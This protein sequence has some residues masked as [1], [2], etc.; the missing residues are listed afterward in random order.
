MNTF[1]NII[2][3]RNINQYTYFQHGI[4]GLFNSIKEQEEYMDNKTIFNDVM[5]QLKKKMRAVRYGV[6]VSSDLLINRN[7]SSVL[8]YE[9][10]INIY[11]Y[12]IS[13]Y[14][15]YTKKLKKYNKNEINSF[16]IK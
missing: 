6:T 13:A 16:R 5:V 4:Q 12:H 9:D 2:L 8:S 1:K 14:F 3:N 7:L 11:Y 15:R 10:I